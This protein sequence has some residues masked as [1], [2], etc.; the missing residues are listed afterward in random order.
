[1]QRKYLLP[2]NVEIT[3]REE[4]LKC[5]ELLFAPSLQSNFHDIEGIH[6]TTY[7]SIVK[8]ENEIKKD[9]FKN[10]VLAG[11]CTMFEG[12]QARIRKEI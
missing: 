6:K 1:M 8:C 9:L 7:E 3:L 10:I 2:N 5:P 12:M 11:G 4:R